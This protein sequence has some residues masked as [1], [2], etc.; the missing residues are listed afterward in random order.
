MHLKINTSNAGFCV[1][2]KGGKFYPQPYTLERDVFETRYIWHHTGEDNI[3]LMTPTQQVLDSLSSMLENIQ[4]VIREKG[5]Y[6]CTQRLVTYYL[7]SRVRSGDYLSLESNFKIKEEIFLFTL[8]HKSAERVLLRLKKLKK[9]GV[10][11]FGSFFTGDSLETD[12]FLFPEGEFLL[13]GL[14]TIFDSRSIINAKIECL[15]F[16]VS[17]L[18]LDLFANELQ[19]SETYL[20]RSSKFDLLSSGESSEYDD[21]R[22]EIAKAN[23]MVFPK[24]PENFSLS[25]ALIYPS[26]H[27]FRVAI[28]AIA[29]RASLGM[30]A[31]KILYNFRQIKLSNVRRF[32]VCKEKMRYDTSNYLEIF[33][34]DAPTRKVYELERKCIWHSLDEWKM[35]LQAA[36]SYT[37]SNR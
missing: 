36:L 31:L 25:D 33:K 14:G 19:T 26:G 17:E 9:D 22:K 30:L 7:T 11:Y 2:P 3:D 12:S 4:T 13:N 20:I 8:N 29:G 15:Y 23:G 5:A 27:A 35:G 10:G 28:E 16:F 24:F 1:L 34:N 6:S 37:D 21:I 18:V 32:S